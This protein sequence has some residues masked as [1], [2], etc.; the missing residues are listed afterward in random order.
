MNYEGKENIFAHQKEEV[1]RTDKKVHLAAKK[2]QLGT[3]GF[4]TNSRPP[5]M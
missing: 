5:Q 1:D 4:G 3:K 2:V